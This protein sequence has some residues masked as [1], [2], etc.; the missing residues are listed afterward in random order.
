MID[1]FIL[2]GLIIF[3]V[4]YFWIDKENLKGFYWKDPY[5]QFNAVRLYFI[6]IVG[7]IVLTVKILKPC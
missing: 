1:Y 5:E 7:I 3:L 6:M 4:I 2:S